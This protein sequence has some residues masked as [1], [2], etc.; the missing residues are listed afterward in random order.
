M[1]EMPARSITRFFV[2][3]IDVLTLLFCIYLLMP[4]VS[5][6]EG[7]ESEEVR[8]ARE[9]KIRYLEDELKKTGKDLSPE[10]LAELEKLNRERVESLKSRVRIRTLEIDEETGKLYYRNARNERAEIHSDAAAAELI[11]RE[12]D[13]AGSKADVFFV[14]VSANPNYP[15]VEMK[16]RFDRWFK[17]VAM[18]Y[19]KLPRRQQP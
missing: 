7:G 3:M 11:K 15:D 18:D 8:K 13:L 12:Q 14:I 5:D 19:Q 17:D 16:P 1:I 4:M 10:Q 6:A 9:A 2:P